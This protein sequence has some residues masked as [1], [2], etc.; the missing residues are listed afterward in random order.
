MKL[1]QKQIAILLWVLLLLFIGRV[2]GQLWVYLYPPSFLPPMEKWYSGLMPYYLLLPSQILITL[3][4][5]KIAFDISLETG[6]F[7]K[8]KP[9]MGLWFRNFGIIYL[10]A[11]ILRFFLQGISIM[12]VFHWVLASFIILVGLF[13]LNKKNL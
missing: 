10:S 11:M 7:G 8:Q 9:R 5:S 12:V 3:L 13:H 4:Y 1:T 2:G 6:F